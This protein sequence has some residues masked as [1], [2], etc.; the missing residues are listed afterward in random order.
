MVGRHE[1][2]MTEEAL[3]K[4][5]VAGNTAAQK[6]LFD[7]Y[8]RVMMGLCLRYASSTEEAQDLAQDG[9]IKVFERLQ[10]FRFEGSLEGWIKRIMVNTSLDH[11]RKNKHI[12]ESLDEGAENHSNL[13]TEA[14]AF[15]RMSA[16]ELMAIVQ[17]LPAGYR[18]VFN[19]YAIEGYSHKEIGQ[20]LGIAESTSKSQYI[21]A[22]ACLQKMLI[23]ENVL[24]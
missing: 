8:S 7:R 15:G 19:L 18:S 13:Q 22:K 17:Q 20:M 11:L 3:V 5:C 4:E 1:T 16:K 24:S 6:K 9:W 12:I 14:E 23:V 10:S 2:V 21:R